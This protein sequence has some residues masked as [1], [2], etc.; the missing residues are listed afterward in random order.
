MKPLEAA[1]K[2]TKSMAMTRT[3]SNKLVIL[4]LNI[5]T[6]F[7]WKLTGFC[8]ECGDPKFEQTKLSRVNRK[9]W[10]PLEELPEELHGFQVETASE[11]KYHGLKL[12]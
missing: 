10:Q 7:C 11:D 3:T 12:V 9:N 6:E 4:N 1:M 8:Q 5:S 2:S